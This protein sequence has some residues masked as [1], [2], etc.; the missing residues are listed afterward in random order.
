MNRWWSALRP[1]ARVRVVPLPQAGVRAVPLYPE[2]REG[3][4]VNLTDE[5]RTE[6]HEALADGWEPFAVIP[7][8]DHREV[9][10]RK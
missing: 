7:H 3:P 5:S 8:E 2:S 4:I 9:W 10:F 6:L 1:Q